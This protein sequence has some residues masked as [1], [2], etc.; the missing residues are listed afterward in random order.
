MAMRSEGLTVHWHGIHQI[1]SPWSDGAAFVTNCPIP[2]GS[3]FEY[4]FIVDQPGTFYYHIHTGSLSAEGAYGFLI[5]NEVNQSEFPH[6]YDDEL[7]VLLSDWYH[8]PARSISAGLQYNPFLWPGTG[9]AILI[10]G[11]GASRECSLSGNPTVINTLYS[12]GS[13]H[14][15]SYSCR[16]KQASLHVQHG[17]TYLMRVLNAASLSFFRFAIEEHN[18]RIVGIGSSLVRAF[19]S[20]QIALGPGQRVEIIVSADR[21]PR[22]Y[23]MKIESDWRG[24][25]AGPPGIAVASIVYD[26]KETLISNISVDRSL[27][28]WDYWNNV[29]RAIPSDNVQCPVQL[30]PDTELELTLQQQYVDRKFGRGFKPPIRTA[31]MP[32]AKMAWTLINNSALSLPSTPYLLRAFESS[33]RPGYD[34]TLWRGSTPIRLSK[35]S[36]VDVIIQ[37]SVAGNG[38]CEQ[39]PWHLHGHD[40]WLI[41][42]GPGKFNSSKDRSR[43]NFV[44]PPRMDTVVGYPSQYGRQRGND[45]AFESGQWMDPC[46]WIAIRFV[47]SNPGMWLF[48]C[49][50]DWHM[51]MGMGI[52]I[53]V[54]SETIRSG[55]PPGYHLCGDVYAVSSGTSSSE[56]SSVTCE[57]KKDP[58]W[59]IGQSAEILFII[60]I[61]VLFITCIY[62]MAKISSSYTKAEFIA[63][64][65][66]Q[67]LK[68]VSRSRTGHNIL[69]E[70][71]EEVTSPMQ[72]STDDATISKP[73]TNATAVYGKSEEISDSLIELL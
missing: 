30:I 52:V 26:E 64:I 15:S 56:D 8:I 40:F 32:N 71:A 48:H 55:P 28:P 72:K 14:S 17:K 21:S 51:E 37:N 22:T 68:S 27:L 69:E 43:F 62:L 47:A 65:K 5:V 61:L 20:D 60:I 39:H 10:N 66:S 46:G 25:E 42:Q 59:S 41:G 23:A 45:A 16:G 53:D 36:V 38:V 57:G 12:D 2:G 3:S 63:M 67:P 6:K 24:S 50:V 11:V 19:E 58:L 1:D 70:L 44:D 31:G 13:S 35:G 73:K 29:L 49:H 18:F 7:L 33:K 54:D 34:S 4:E 9:S